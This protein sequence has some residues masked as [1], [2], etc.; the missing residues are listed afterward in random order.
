MAPT[1]IAIVSITLGFRFGYTV[2]LDPR[3]QRILEALIGLTSEEGANCHSIATTWLAASATTVPSDCRYQEPS[4]PLPPQ[5]HPT[6][7]PWP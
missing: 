1:C 5:A 3:E 6:C 4:H 2:I 7:P